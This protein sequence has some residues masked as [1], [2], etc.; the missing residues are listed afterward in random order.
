MTDAAARFITPLTM[1]SLSGHRVVQSI[2]QEADDPS[3]PHIELARWADAMI[4]AP[5]SANI[6]AKLA[7]GLCDDI[8]CLVAAALPKST[9]VLLAPAMNAQMWEHAITQRNVATLDGLPGWSRIGPE[10]GWQACRTEGAGRMAEP[11]AIAS[12]ALELLRP[13]G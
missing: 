3:S 8:V 1:E 5:A 13:G 7:S 4:I 11:D 12:A 9:P 6:L 10:H 2:W